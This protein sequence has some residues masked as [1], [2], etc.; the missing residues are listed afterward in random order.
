MKA[1]E[2]EERERHAKDEAETDQGHVCALGRPRLS[3]LGIGHQDRWHAP[4]LACGG[5]RTARVNRRG[6]GAVC[7][8][9][10]EGGEGEPRRVPM[11]YGVVRMITAVWPRNLPQ[12]HVQVH[13]RAKRDRQR[14]TYMV[15]TKIFSHTEEHQH[16][17]GRGEREERRREE[18]RVEEGMGREGEEKG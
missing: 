2:R 16:E 8:T 3:S 7:R 4:P 14:K 9:G 12:A 17:T 10:G 18:K 15:V 1:R 5:G 11:Q 6:Q 13:T